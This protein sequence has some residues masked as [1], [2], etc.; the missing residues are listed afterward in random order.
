MRGP[1]AAAG[2]PS[3]G[4]R[5]TSGLGYVDFAGSGV[6]HAVGGVA[7]LAGAIVLGPRI[8][9]YNKDGSANTIP[10]H[11]LPMAMLGTFIL[12]FGWFGF[13]A[14]STFAATDV[15]FAVVATNT[16]IAGGVRRHRRRCSTRCTRATGSPIPG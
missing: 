9:K 15:R 1:G 6:V 5:S 13:N 8:G 10:G 11:H 7:G 4:T 3:S 16:A 12:L 14:A 2:S